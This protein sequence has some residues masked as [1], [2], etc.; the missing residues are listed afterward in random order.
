M[1]VHELTRDQMIEL[2]Q[3]YLVKLDEEG[4]LN[5][6]LYNDPDDKTGLTYDELADADTLIPDAIVYNE[7]AGYEFVPEDFSVANP[8]AL[9]IEVSNIIWEI[10]DDDVIERFGSLTDDNGLPYTSKDFG[11]PSNVILQMSKAKYEDMVEDGDDDDETMEDYI[12]DR[13]ANEYGFCVTNPTWSFIH[14]NPTTKEEDEPMTITEYLNSPNGEELKQLFD[15]YFTDAKKRGGEWW[16]CNCAHFA[17]IS[18]AWIAFCEGHFDTVDEIDDGF[19]DANPNDIFDGIIGW[20]N[21]SEDAA[22]VLTCNHDDAR[23]EELR[24]AWRWYE[25]YA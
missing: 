15:N 18:E 13:L 20:A 12:S 23:D 11:L 19:A 14:T 5:E 7:Y 4:T 10:D 1:N 3:A 9:T 16:R 22:I 6:V 25:D 17:F 2:K 24:D 21:G 8:D